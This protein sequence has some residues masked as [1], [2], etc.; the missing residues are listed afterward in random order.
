MGEISADLFLV[1]VS[2]T[3]VMTAQEAVQAVN[4]I[5]PKLAIPMHYDK[6]V[7]SPEDAKHLKE[8]AAVAVEVLQ[9]EAG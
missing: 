9:K 2:G 8:N 7:G 4:D 3:Y 6:V 5:K 1:P